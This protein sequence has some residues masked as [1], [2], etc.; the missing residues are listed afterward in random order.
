MNSGFRVGVENGA[1][2][3]RIRGAVHRDNQA[4]ASWRT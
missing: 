4:A 1:A 2:K 3:N